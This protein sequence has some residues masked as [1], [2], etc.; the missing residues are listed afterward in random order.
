MTAAGQPRKSFVAVLA[1]VL[2]LVLAVWASPAPRAATTERVVTDPQTGLAIFGIDPVAYFT[3]QEPTAGREDHE[4]RY[5]GAIWRFENEGNR[6][7]FRN[8]PLVYMPRF[9]GY[10]PINVARGVATAGYPEL[11]VVTQNRLYLFYTAQARR[12]FIANPAAA[13]AAA[14]AH[15]QKVEKGLVE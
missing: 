15:W 1:V 11:W 10:D 2:S 14:E 9:G 5:A 8:D 6:Q 4:L 7:A 13:I 12:V 3:R